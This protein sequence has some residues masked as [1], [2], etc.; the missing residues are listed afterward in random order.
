AVTDT[1]KASNF[2]AGNMT[3]NRGVLVGKPGGTV[4]AEALAESGKSYIVYLWGSVGGGNL[5]MNLPA[6]TYDA[7]WINPANGQTVKTQTVSGSSAAAIASPAFSEDMALLVTLTGSGG[8]TTTPPPTTTPSGVNLA[9]NKT[10]TASSSEDGPRYDGPNAVDGNG[11][12]RWS[13]ADKIDPQW[14]KVDLGQT[15]SINRVVLKWE[16]A[17]ADHYRIEVSNDNAAWQTVYNTTSGNGSTDDI[18]FNTVS[19]RYVRMYGTH[20]YDARYGYSIWEMEVYGGG[21]TTTPPPVNTTKSYTWIEGEN[22]ALT[23]PMST[24]SDAGASN[25]KYIASPQTSTRSNDG[26]GYAS[27]TINV[28]AS[29]S[30]KLWAR[31]YWLGEAD[32]SFYASMDGG[33]ESVLGNVGA[34]NSWIWVSGSTYTLGAGSHTIRIRSREDGARVD[35]LLLTSDTAYYPSGTGSADNSGL[36][37]SGGGTTTPP[38]TTTPTG[39]NLALYKTATASSSEDGPRYDGPNAVDGNGGTRWSSA[40]KIDPQ[41]LKVDLGQTQSINR[42]VLKW[43]TA[44]ADHYRIEVSNDN[45]AWQTVYSTTSGNG[46]TDDITFNTV[47]ARYVRMYGTHRYDARYGYS[48]WEMEVYGGGT[49]TTP[50]PV[51]TTK[52]YTWIEGE[53][54]ALTSP[55]ST[56]SDAG[57]SNGK[58]IASPQTSTRS[59]DGKG[60]ASYTINVPASGSYK[61]WARTYWLGEADN[62][63]YASMD[64][65]AESVLGNVGANNSWIWVSGSTY[66]L[67]AG[68]HTIR[69]RSRED[70]ARVDK[71]LLTSDTAYYPS[72]TGSADNSGLTGSGGGTTTPPPT[73]TPSGVN[74]ALYKTAMASSSEYAPKYGAAPAFDGNMGSRWSSALYIDPQWLAVDLGQAQSIN[75]VVLKWEGAY[76]T[77]YQ[78]QVSSDNAN[79]RTVYSTTSGDGGTDDVTFAS[80]SARYVRMYGTRRGSTYGY[81]IWEMEVYGGTSAMSMQAPAYSPETVTTA[82]VAPAAPSLGTTTTPGST[83]SAPVTEKTAPVSPV[84]G[85]TGTRVIRR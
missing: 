80:T 66:T 59:N 2:A 23:S 52:S 53:N 27:Y 28:P 12:T 3:P 1:V 47:N 78:I 36:T 45:A 17:F 10:A 76:A 26:K 34:N 63:F 50:P 20:R 14:L 74:L 13:S 55:M 71:L 83:I 49:T 37:G 41:W 60:Y 32:N 24:G 16:T 44:F 42:V 19:A 38:P 62:S 8:G 68:S 51:N 21:T 4:Y 56:G 31:T 29:G 11:G 43:E 48:I 33:A 18:T 73:T 25:G 5:T 77:A 40:D 67:G 35:K 22:G 70:G 61:L 58:Y 85:R 82:P 6:G 57:A 75:R 7:K 69:I 79:W 46:S 9:L 64:G 15:Q 30:Y 39:V 65:G 81:S 54:G 72:G 84:T